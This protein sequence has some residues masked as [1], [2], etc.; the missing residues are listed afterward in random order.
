MNLKLYLA[1]GGQLDRTPCG[2]SGERVFIS[3]FFVILSLHLYICMHIFA[4]VNKVTFLSMRE[5]GKWVDHAVRGDGL[6]KL[7]ME[8]RMKGSFPF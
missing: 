3:L 1:F 6:M 8:G 4:F 5:T 2:L 7:S